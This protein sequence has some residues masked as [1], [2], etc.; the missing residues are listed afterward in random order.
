MFLDLCLIRL[1]VLYEAFEFY[2]KTPYHV[3][4]LFCICNHAVTVFEHTQF[5]SCTVHISCIRVGSPI[6]ERATDRI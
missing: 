2:L 4:I 3:F 5:S 6:L 1:I